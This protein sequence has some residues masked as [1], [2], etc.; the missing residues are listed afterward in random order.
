MEPLIERDLEKMSAGPTVHDTLCPFLEAAIH[1]I[2]YSRR[3]YPQE[4]FE[5]R[6]H[7]DVSVF[8][9]RHRDLNEHIALVVRGTRQLLERGEA[10]ALV[11]SILGTRGEILERFRFE[12]RVDHQP[13]DVAALQAH[14]RGF[15]LKLH[16][17]EAMLAPLPADAELSFT[18]ELHTLDARSAQPLPGPL[19][20]EWVEADVARELRATSGGSEPSLVPLKS[21]SLD[22]IT[23]DLS[24]LA[25]REP[26]T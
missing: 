14:L 12:L 18:T 11:V 8:R 6:R 19:R 1:L 4:I 9:S 25:A 13:V 26:P 21:L 16:M 3:V 24:V 15:L 22:G 5:R 17:C 7:L 2:L 10:D 23:L 20:E